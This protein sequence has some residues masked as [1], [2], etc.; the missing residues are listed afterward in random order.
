MINDNLKLL[1]QLALNQVNVI[2]S[3]YIIFIFTGNILSNQ[4]NF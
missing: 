2:I 3:R 4:L 1:L